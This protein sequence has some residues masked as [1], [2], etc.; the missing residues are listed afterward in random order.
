MVQASLLVS[1]LSRVLLVYELKSHAMSPFISSWRFTTK[2][3][4][5]ERRVSFSPSH[6][7]P[8][9]KL[10]YGIAAVALNSVI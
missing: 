2:K 8:R 1:F 9:T 6:T 7:V 10:L 4:N 3:P 5:V